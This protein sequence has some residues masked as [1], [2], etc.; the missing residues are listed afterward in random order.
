MNGHMDIHKCE[1]V[2]K[3]I[4][5]AGK[6]KHEP[7]TSHLL[8]ITDLVPRKKIP[9]HHTLSLELHEN[10]LPQRFHQRYSK[11]LKKV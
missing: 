7:G 9:T 11:V 6:M 5:M 3:L 2:K 1:I 8:C 4:D 10:S